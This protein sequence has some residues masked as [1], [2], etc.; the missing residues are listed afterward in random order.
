MAE[1]NLGLLGLNVTRSSTNFVGNA[2]PVDTYRFTISAA[3][4]FNLAL[5]GLTQNANVQLFRDVN[6]NGVIDAADGGA[7]ASSVRTASAD[8]FI[9]R[10]LTTTGAYIVRVL[11]SGSSSTN[12][13]LRLSNRGTGPSNLLP[14]EFNAGSLTAT[15][16]SRTNSVGATDTVDVYR[17]TLGAVGTFNAA[18]TGISAGSN[19]NM[20]LIRDV[21][22]NRIV[23]SADVLVSS[24]STGSND[25]AI[26]VRSLAAGNYFLQ[27]YRFSGATSNYTLRLSRTASLPSNLVTREFNLGTPSST[28]FSR[29]DRLS[30]RDASDTYRFT[31]G[32]SSNFSATITGI[33]TGTDI[34]IRLIQDVNNNGIVDASDEI[35]RSNNSNNTDDSIN[36]R[37]LAAGNYIVQ[38]YLY[39]GTGSNYTLRAS[40]SLNNLIVAETNVGTLALSATPFTTNGSLSAVDAVETYRFTLDSNANFNAVLTGLAVGNDFDLR[41]IRDTNSNG[42]VDSGEQIVVANQS[43]NVDDV[44]N[45][46]S[47]AA[48]DYF[49]QVSQFEGG[50]TYS[51]NLSNTGSF[52]PSNL[53]P[54]EVTVGTVTSTT[55]RTGSLGV[56]NASDTFRFNIST[57]RS[58]SLSLSGLSADADLRLIQDV[59][60][61]GIVDAGEE[62]QRSEGTGTG[63]ENITRSLAAGN[64][65]AQAYFYAQ[66]GSTSYNL[67][68]TPAP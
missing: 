58:V 48:G 19:V 15:P 47:L 57:D 3:A 40:S 14:L 29:N 42:I 38:T 44:I 26:S 59:N 56:N 52:G 28:P 49:L 5:T 4:N 63:D 66:T 10:R 23:D 53:L 62:L 32:S 2:D 41:L 11:R 39:E 17:F 13:T 24:I 18:L 55:T 27:T 35:V 12:Y 46:R 9:N 51:L 34:D 60:N 61:N 33:A 21:N 6:N 65:I 36:L 8:E 30:T 1:V 22:N 7:I 37:N 64:Y 50:G 31:L 68:I 20:R 25:D 54:T 43:N 45:V 16:Y 67:T